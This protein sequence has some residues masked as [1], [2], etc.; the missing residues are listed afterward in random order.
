M[1]ILTKN[2]KNEILTKS[3]RKNGPIREG[4]LVKTGN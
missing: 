1:S 4:I 2:G 3:G